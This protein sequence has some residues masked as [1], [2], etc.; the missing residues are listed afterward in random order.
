MRQSQRSID[1]ASADTNNVDLEFIKQ[2]YNSKK[3]KP[4]TKKKKI[5]RK[6]SPPLKPDETVTSMFMSQSS[7][8]IP[9]MR[10]PKPKRKTPF[11]LAATGL[12][13]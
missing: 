2:N 12:V 3:D 1:W 8:A 13:L 9:I 11:K 7:M 6:E 5:P 10:R 4:F